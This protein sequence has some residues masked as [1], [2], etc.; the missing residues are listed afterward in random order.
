MFSVK[1]PK[2]CSK[3]STIEKKSMEKFSSNCSSE[4]VPCS[5]DNSAGNLSTNCDKVWSDLENNEKTFIEEC[6]KVFVITLFG[7]ICSDN[8]E[9]II[10]SQRCVF[11]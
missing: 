1:F 6:A 11:H 7:E 4:R 3:T 10:F 5:F 8:G 9:K 2:C